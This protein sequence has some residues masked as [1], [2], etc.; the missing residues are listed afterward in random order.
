MGQQRKKGMGIEKYTP[1]TIPVGKMR[2]KAAI[3]MSIWI[4]SV[5]S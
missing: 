5:A 1:R 3:W 2:P 4:H